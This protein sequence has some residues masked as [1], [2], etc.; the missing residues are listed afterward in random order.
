MIIDR[1][2]HLLRTND[3]QFGFQPCSSTS[4]CSWMVFETIDCYLRHGSTV[5][6]CLLDCTKAFDTI[7][8]SKLFEKLIAAKVPPIVIRILICI[9]RKQTAKVRWKGYHS[10]EFPIRNGVRQGAVISP[11]FFNFYMN[12]LF[13]LLSRSGSGCSI[14]NFYAGCFAYADDIFLI[15]ASR[16]GL[17]D[18]LNIANKYVEE[19]NISFST[20]KDPSKSKTKGVVF[21]RKKL[22]FEPEPL[23]LNNA[24]LPWVHQAKYLGNE[25][26]DIPT[27]LSKDVK[28]KRARFIERN[29]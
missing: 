13:N 11:L 19:H 23:V 20:N 16:S 12:E 2:G 14:E 5:Y 17:Q 3:F 26:E 6:G 8:H 9:Y 24:K 25:I 7:M 21:S 28:I 15:S 18:M 22:N 10:E 29:F 4:L 27:G 1:Y